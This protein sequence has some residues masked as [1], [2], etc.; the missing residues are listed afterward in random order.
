LIYDI[1]QLTSLI[2]VYSFVAYAGGAAGLALYKAVILAAIYLSAARSSVCTSAYFSITVIGYFQRAG[3]KGAAVLLLLACA[4][5]VTLPAIARRSSQCKGGCIIA[6]G[7]HPKRI[8]ECV[9]PKC[10]VGGSQQVLSSSSAAFPP[11]TAVTAAAAAA[12]A[13]FQQGKQ[14]RGFARPRLSGVYCD[15][16]DRE[17]NTFEVGA[18]EQ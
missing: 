15:F 6:S 5:A 12:A 16:C 8:C 18:C 3:M 4:A 1:C 9:I 13:T 10:S 11:A 14:P 17:V 2:Y 7:V